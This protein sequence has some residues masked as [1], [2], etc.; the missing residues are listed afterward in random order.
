MARK[1][2][3]NKAYLD[4]GRQLWV[5]ACKQLDCHPRD[6]RPEVFAEW[7][8]SK[9]A[10][11]LPVS[12]RQYRLSAM[13]FLS[14]ESCPSSEEDR[15]GALNKLE[16]LGA[17]NF[18][19]NNVWLKSL[20]R[21]SRQK[22][23]KVTKQDLQELLTAFRKKNG[24]WDAYSM[25]WLLANTIVGLRPNEWVSAE[26]NVGERVFLNV[27][28]A[29]HDEQR[30]NGSHRSI[31][32]T[33]LEELDRYII[34]QHIRNCRKF[35]TSSAEWKKFYL[36]CKNALYQ[37]SRKTWPKRETYPT[38]YSG[39]HQFTADAKASGLTKEQV[40]ALLGHSR[41]ITATKHYAGKKHGKPGLKVLPSEEDVE[42]LNERE[43]AI[44]E[45]MRH[46]DGEKT[47]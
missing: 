25:I 47:L 35:S 22:S 1:D 10:E 18:S 42:R 40:A 17:D 24:K 16:S 21:T 14:T 23:K 26:L 41:T 13:E 39:R 19:G 27:Q 34:T 28:N 7:L 11:L 3:T 33:Q 43:V 12:R 30:G 15:R 29:K 31:E 2:C 36:A 46:E 45:A 37:V 4:R 44:A 38:L 20:N 32:L 8:T 5:R 9:L 6:L